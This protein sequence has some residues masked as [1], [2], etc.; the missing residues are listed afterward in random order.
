M[1]TLTGISVLVLLGVAVAAIVL[2]YRLGASA[3]RVRLAQL[4]GQ[5]EALRE[6]LDSR[7]SLDNTLQPL[8]Q[9]MS[10]LATQ[11]ETAERS[12]LTAMT[13]LSEQV[14]SVGRQM[15]EATK[16][17]EE[18][19]H[20][21]TQ[22]LSRTQSQGSWG[23]MQLRRLVE[24]SGMLAHVHFVEQASVHDEQRLLRPDMLIDLGQGRTVVVDAK[25][26]LDAFLDADLDPATASV[27]HAAAVSDHI[28]RLSGK[29]YW[30][31]V[32]T[33][34]FVIMFLPAEHLLGVA[35]RERP[36]LLQTAFDKKIVLATPTTLMA[37][38]RSIS[39]AW[40][41]AAMADQA[42]DVLDAG[43]QLFDR[44]FTMAGHVTKMGK[45]L[46]DAV[47]GYNQFV[48]SLDSRVMP[49]TRRLGQMVAPEADPADLSELDI[50]PRSTNS[51]E[52]VRD[53]G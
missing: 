16:G 3:S 12:R 35:L 32:G 28:S 8:Q 22:A 48:G 47:T 40:Q 14:L 36:E 39:W 6:Q 29:Q 33:P 17:V 19:A 4:Q 49:A 50:R 2:A 23:E 9:A 27:Q 10:T 20:R 30:R 46:S 44:L 21:I 11:V 37:T 5:N 1:V 51:L 45:S 25:V 42:R 15:G 18:Q 53:T 26:S 38:L 31:A 34:E 41:Q 24:A 43:R 52:P 13:G 7:G